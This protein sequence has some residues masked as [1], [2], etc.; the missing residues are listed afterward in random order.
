MSTRAAKW[1][2]WLLLCCL[3]PVPYMLGGVEVAPIVRLVFF[4]GII[5][6]LNLSEGPGGAY[7]W[8]FLGLAFAQTAFLAGALYLIAALGGRV[9]GRLPPARRAP[10]LVGLALAAGSLCIAFA[11]YSTP[12]SSVSVRSGLLGVFR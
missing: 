8:A 3:L 6:L 2:I 7:W 12:M 4:T 10:L 5:V 9:L 11:P 1:A